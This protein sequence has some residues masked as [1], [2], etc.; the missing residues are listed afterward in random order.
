MALSKSITRAYG[1]P[2]RIAVIPVGAEAIYAGAFLNFDNSGYAVKASDSA[3]DNGFAGI[4][5]T[6]AANSAGS[7]GD[8]SVR[9]AMG[10]KRLW[11]SYSSAVQ[12]DAGKPVYAT[13]DDTLATTASNIDAC[14]II[15]DV[16]VGSGWYVTFYTLR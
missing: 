1:E 11:Y 9:V 7:A 13:A 8:L 14:G 2:A 4:A 16:V 15:E 6:E 12:A 3:S 10:V 5:E